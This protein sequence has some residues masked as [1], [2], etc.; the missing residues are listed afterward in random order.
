MSRPSTSLYALLVCVLL[1]MANVYAEAPSLHDRFEASEH[2]VMDAEFTPGWFTSPPVTTDWEAVELPHLWSESVSGTLHGWYRFRLSDQPP[3]EATAIYL[4]RFSMN[5]GIW[6]NNEFLGDGGRFTEPMARNWNRPF[7]YLLPASAWREDNPNYLY[8][9]LG[10]YP[11]WGHLPPVVI[12]PYDA[13]RA[14]YE[15]RYLWQ[16]S[17][18]QA[19]WLL[20]L[21]AALVALTFWATDRRS[22]IYGIFAL[23]CLAWSG[24]SLNN[25]VQ[26][27]PVSASVWWWGVHSSIDWYGVMLSMF[28]HRL[29]KLER[30]PLEIACVG[31]ALLATLIY[32]MVDLDTLARINSYVHA[33]TLGIAIYIMITAMVVAL[34]RPSVEA[35]AL[36]VCMLTIAIFGIHDLSMN[37]LIAPQLWRHQF[38]WLQFSA[39]ILM[40]TML[41]ILSRRFHL[42]LLL[43]LEAEQAIREERERIYSDVHDDVGSRLLTLVYATEGSTQSTLA[44]ETL[45]EV[46]AIVRGANRTH[47]TLAELAEAWQAEA[48]ERCEQ[49]GITLDWRVGQL[50]DHEYGHQTKYHLQRVVREL[51]TNAIKHAAASRIATHLDAD[52]N[53]IQ[54]SIYD[55]GRHIDAASFQPGS[56]MTSIRHRIEELGGQV[57]WQVTEDGCTATLFIPRYAL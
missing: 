25:F 30:R 7:I 33:G 1:H 44:R 54:L 45:H 37:A 56:G 48:R 47:D 31:Y 40:L 38:F 29:L 52:D 53:R 18:S 4:W 16:I 9:R 35:I 19:T 49:A 23:V 36:S 10:A 57:D 24:Y 12:G 42:A 41:V 32:A 8:V 6:L 50:P 39:P 2:D 55:N 14:E 34:R 5:A 13:L 51:I 21:L 22:S 28:A 26:N 46:R 43:R 17:F 27:I 15:T 20:S 3:N 11:G